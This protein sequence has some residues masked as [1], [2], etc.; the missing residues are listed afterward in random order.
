[1]T[2]VPQRYSQWA[3]ITLAV[4]AI[5]YTLHVAKEVLLPITLALIFA[6]LMAPSVTRLERYRIPRALGTILLI[7]MVLAVLTLGLYLLSSS[8]MTWLQ[9]LPEARAALHE[10]LLSVQQEVAEVDSATKELDTLSQAMS[11]A[12]SSATPQVVLA[13]PSLSTE[14][15]LGIRDFAVYGGLSV[16]LLYFLLAS[17]DKLLR[18]FIETLPRLQDKKRALRLAQQAQSQMSRYLLTITIVNGSVGLVTAM[19]LWAFGFPDPALWGALAA[20]LRFVPYLGVS[21]TVVLLAIVATVSYASM[22]LMVAVPLGYLL[23]TAFVGQV[24][25]P[26]VHGFRFRLNPIVVFVWI[27]F[28]GWLWGASGVLLA[29]PLLTLFQVLCQ[30]SE[31]LAPVAHLIGDSSE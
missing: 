2:E 31:T 11:G 9:K 5:L 30:H 21:L 14:L 18:R 24:I 7:S 16:I 4:L 26:Y 22:A 25:D 15:W 13:E 20:A 1:M 10:Q 28:W 23:F 27:F 29:V 19:A 3:V 12:A 6:L 8:A 17:G